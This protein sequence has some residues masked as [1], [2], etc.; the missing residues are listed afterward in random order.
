[1][2]DET[3][4]ELVARVRQGDIAAFEAIVDRHRA[5]LVA[6]AAGRL[7]SL[8]DAEDVAQEAF[9][10]AYFRLHQLRKP[11][12][13]L[14]WLRR[15]TDRL[16]LMRLRRPRE[17]PVEPARVERMRAA[18][19]AQAEASPRELLGRLPDGMRQAVALTCLAGYTSGEAAALL[20][21]KEGTVRSRLSR[22]R[23]VLREEFGMAEREL[24]AGRPGAEFTQEVVKRIRHWERFKGSE[25][26][27][28]GMVEADPEW[29][30]L[31]EV[32]VELG[33]VSPK[34]RSIRQQIASLEACHEHYV[35]NVEAALEM[36]GAMT[37]GFVL[38]CG[39]ACAARRGEARAYAE[40][41]ETWRD[42]EKPAGDADEHTREV[43]GLLGERTEEKVRLV[44]H[45]IGKLRDNG[46]PVYADE[47][48]DFELTESRIQHLEIC[49]YNWRENLRIVLKEIAAGKRLFEWHV[50]DGYNAHGDCPD[51]VSELREMMASAAAWA[52]G[53][54]GRAGRW[55]RALGRMSAEKRW[56][57][58]SLCKHVSV[59]H[60]K[61]GGDR[62]LA[63]PSL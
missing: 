62:L 37:P 6:L 42:G 15:L 44:E 58:A 29:R 11:E 41:L 5:A 31:V 34:A 63:R 18:S 10:Q 30:R 28:V 49:N 14:A 16:A 27:K 57:V 24:A 1:M 23:A 20:G 53:D 36:V 51:R 32:E 7:G 59:Q 12:A 17:E 13:L 61:H 3:D 19:G 2:Q 45:V 40:A 39:Q 52:G 21:V 50:A 9:V 60:E 46:Y 4:G 26:E 8:A 56:L 33:R 55:G 22:A 48:E 47:D 35:E 54:R 25:E 43:F 38:D